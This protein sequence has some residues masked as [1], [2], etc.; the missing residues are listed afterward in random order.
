MY[1]LSKSS[2]KV[3]DLSVGDSVVVYANDLPMNI[4]I[5][6]S[7]MRRILFKWLNSDFEYMKLLNDEE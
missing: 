7:R 3:G 4:Y 6:S 2:K 1:N 5:P